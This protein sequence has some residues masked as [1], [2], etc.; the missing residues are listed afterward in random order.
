MI[1][2]RSHYPHPMGWSSLIKVGKAGFSQ[3]FLFLC[4]CVCVCVCMCI[5]DICIENGCVNY[6]KRLS[7]NNRKKYVR[8]NHEPSDITANLTPHCLSWASYLTYSYNALNV[9]KELKTSTK[10]TVSWELIQYR[11]ARSEFLPISSFNL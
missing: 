3:T 6:T 1:I 5:H 9:H 8:H 7:V 10:E 11:A 2:Y 4:V